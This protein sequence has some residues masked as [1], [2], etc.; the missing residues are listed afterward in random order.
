M[1]IVA[2]PT[3]VRQCCARLTWAVAVAAPAMVGTCSESQSV[4]LAETT[5]LVP[6]Q[7]V[8]FKAPEPLRV[9]GRISELCLQVLP[10][11]SVNLRTQGLDWGVRRSDG[12]LVKVGAAMVRPDSSSD[13]ISSSGYSMS[14]REDCLVIRPSIHDSL[15]P[16]FVAVRITVS[17]SLTVSKI[18]WTSGNG[19]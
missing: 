5:T 19:W 17:D 9:V 8:A 6:H 12:V 14:A 16:P 4:K 2:A 1:A 13:T 3:V 18:T 11:D 7:P 10:P 15:R